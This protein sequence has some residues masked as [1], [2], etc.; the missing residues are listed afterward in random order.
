M[1]TGVRPARSSDIDQIAEIQVQ[2]WQDLYANLLRDTG[3]GLDQTSLADQWGDAVLHPPQASTRVLVATQGEEVVGFAAVGP[4][5]DP[6]LGTDCGEIHALV[7]RTDH[8]R[9]GHGSR[10]MAACVDHLR[11]CG[12]RS[13]ATWTLLDDEPRRAFWQSAG[14][15]PDS[16]R[17]TL[18][19]SESP[20]DPG[21]T[22]TE[23][24][25]VADIADDPNE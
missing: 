11:S 13:M 4:C 2:A 23:I 10:L 18:G 16:A 7:V 17:R 5:Y 8:L 19:L 3:L 20:V 12:F 9:C 14:W 6:D 21:R 1:P 22:V 24:R 25:L 15:G